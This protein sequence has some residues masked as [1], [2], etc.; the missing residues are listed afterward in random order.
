VSKSREKYRKSGSKFIYIQIR[1]VT[2]TA[3]ISVK[4]ANNQEI[5][6]NNF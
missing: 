5:F 6:K 3:E 2:Y 1:R 4:P